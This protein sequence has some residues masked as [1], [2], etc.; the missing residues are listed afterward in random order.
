[1]I[2]L[3]RFGVIG[4]PLNICFVDDIR[5]SAFDLGIY[6]CNILADDS[7]R[8]ENETAEKK[9]NRE[10]KVE[11]RYSDAQAADDVDDEIN[12]ARKAKHCTR[13]ERN[14]QRRI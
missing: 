5:R 2:V 4:I 11:R 10:Q 14:A 9:K 3:N 6:S 7:E 12:K 13:Q 8:D 1:M